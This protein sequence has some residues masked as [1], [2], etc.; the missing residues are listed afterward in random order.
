MATITPV[1]RS[2]R[3]PKRCVDQNDGSEFAPVE[4]VVSTSP[5]GS[6]VAEPSVGF[7]PGVDVGTVAGSVVELLPPVACSST[8]WVYC[9]AFG[10]PRPGVGSN[11]THPCPLMY[12][13]GHAC[14]CSPRTWY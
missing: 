1:A 9:S 3:P 8:T 4:P 13:S 11:N 2:A 5:F 7:E 14:A 12:T 10:A 6:V